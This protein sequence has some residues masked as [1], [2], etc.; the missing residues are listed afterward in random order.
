MRITFFSNYLNHHQLPFCLEMIK[1]LGKENFTFV[2]CKAIH[3]ERIQ[4]GYEDMDIKYPF[5]LRAYESDEDFQQAILLAQQS[6]VAIIGAADAIFAEIRAKNN[7]LTFLFRERIFKNSTLRRFIPTTAWEI[8]KRYIRFRD[9]NFYILCASAF[10]ADD[11]SLCGFPRY[12]CLKWGYF[13]VFKEMSGQ[14]N[15]S[16]KLRLMWCG[17]MIWWKH[18]EHAIE[19]ARLLKERNIDFEMLMVGNGEKEA[20]VKDLVY[21]YRLKQHIQI[22]DFMSPTEIRENMERSDIYL[23]TSGREEGWGV[24]LNEAMNSR[25]AIIANKQAGSSTYLLDEDSGCFYDGSLNSLEKAVDELLLS[26][27]SLLGAKAYDRIKRIWN[28]SNAANNFIKFIKNNNK[29]ANEG[30]CSLV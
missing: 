21:K 6:D 17:R 1:L 16:E 3:R 22:C 20:M 4:M 28:P 2:A 9:K 10:A 27:V 26:N 29:P 8:Y 24:V 14:A 5:V 23:F 15:C 30:P 18:P 13:P 25:C 11:F 12:K 19:V 7:R